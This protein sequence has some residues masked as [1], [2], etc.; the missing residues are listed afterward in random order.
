MYVDLTPAR[1]AQSPPPCL[2]P[3]TSQEALTRREYE[4][5]CRPY[6]FRS[7][8]QRSHGDHPAAS[9]PLSTASSPRPGSPSN[10]G[11]RRAQRSD[12]VL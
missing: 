6:P 11:R 8:S 2:R 12:S 10:P 5:I 1:P 3:R 9:P 4:Q 7:Q